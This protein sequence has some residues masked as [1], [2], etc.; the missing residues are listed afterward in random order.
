MSA[1]FRT[2]SLGLGPFKSRYESPAQ[3]FSSNKEPKGSRQAEQTDTR[4][5]SILPA[6]L[7]FFGTGASSSAQSSSSKLVAESENAQA[8]SK[9]RKRQKQATASA[10]PASRSAAAFLQTPEALKAFLN[11]H[12]L[13]ISGSDTPA[14]LFDW[15]E[16]EARYPMLKWM[17][18]ELH[19]ERQWDLTAV[20]RAAWPISFEGRDLIAMAPTGSGKTL[21]YLVPLLHHIFQIKAQLSGSTQSSPPGP[22]AVILSP[23]RELAT[24]IYDETRR[25]LNATP[26]ALR[27]RE[28]EACST[29]VSTN[30]RKKKSKKGR[31]ANE[32]GD[33]KLALLTGGEKIRPIEATKT[34]SYLTGGRGA[35]FD[36]VIATPL[37]LLKAI[38]AEGWNLSNVSHIILDEADTLLS[39]AF[40]TQTDSL[41]SQCTATKLQKSL[42]SATLP[43]SIETL[44]RSFLSLDCIRL[45]VGS[46]DASSEDVD[47]E[48]RFVGSEE[49]KLLEL[50]AMLKTGQIKPPAL[51]FVQS[52]ERAKDLYSEL[53]YD[54]LRLEAIH[55]ERTRS[56]R[57]QVIASFKRGDVWLLICTEVI[58]RGLDFK[59]VEL[60]INYDLPQSAESYVHRVGRTGRAGRKGRAVTFFTKDDGPRLPTIVN[61]VRRSSQSAVENIP[62][63]LIEMPKVSKKQ[64]KR[65][66]TRVPQRESVADASGSRTLERDRDR[67]KLGRQVVE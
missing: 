47:Q 21:A 26:E 27:L 46:K 61:L 4:T 13:K 1:T 19:V 35:K 56:Q 12:R 7:D 64:R 59:G 2:L 20:Q 62:S 48:L 65:L 66:K 63:Y 34:G 33:V 29:I 30:G 67:R 10:V 45:I 38:E 55:S 18:H 57:E 49:G 52:I 43:S 31:G 53:A 22:A 9:K 54:G 14:P 44:S 58:S 3:I 28:E 50:R 41:L 40:V 42:F 51:L 6:E 36:I 25:L 8:S 37:R 5:R 24:Q 16:A 11:K 15:S 60:V 23:T 32:T 39:D 17:A